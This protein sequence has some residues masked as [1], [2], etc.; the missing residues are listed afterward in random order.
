MFSSRPGP[1]PDGE[2][3]SL[4]TPNVSGHDSMSWG[5]EGKITPN[6]EP[7]LSGAQ[8]GKYVATVPSPPPRKAL[9]TGTWLSHSVVLRAFADKGARCCWEPGGCQLVTRLALVDT[10]P[11]AHG[12]RTSSHAHRGREHSS[13]STPS[14]T[15]LRLS[16]FT[17]GS[18]L[19]GRPVNDVPIKSFAHFSTGSAAFFLLICSSSLYMM[20]TSLSSGPCIANILFSL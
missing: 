7:L 8:W 5:R 18:R 2:E 20:G 4:P 19:L 9:H 15:A 1:T 10:A 6:R 14:P 17:C 16:T 12:G 3:W 11:V 13:G